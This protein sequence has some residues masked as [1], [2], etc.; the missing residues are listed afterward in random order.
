MG[1]VA[2]LLIQSLSGQSLTEALP[3]TVGVT[4]GRPGRYQL[5]Y[6]VPEQYWQA[7]SNKRISTGTTGEQ[8]EFRW[9]GCQSVVIGHHPMTGSYRYLPGQSFEECEIAEAPLWMVEQM[10]V[11]KPKASNEPPAPGKDDSTPCTLPIDVK[12]PLRACLGRKNRKLIDDGAPEGNR[13]NAGAA[14]ARDLIG[15]ANYLTSIGQAFD[16]NARELLE[17]FCSRCTPPLTGKECDRLWRSATKSNPTPCLSPDKIEAC[18]KAWHRKHQPGQPATQTGKPSQEIDVESEDTD[19]KAAQQCRQLQS[20]IGDYIRLNT[21][22]QEIELE[23]KPIQNLDLLYLQLACDY[24]IAISKE[25]CVDIVRKLA[26]H[27]PYSPVAEH[28]KKIAATVEPLPKEH[29]DRCAERYLGVTDDI[30]QLMLKRTLIAAVAR[31]LNPG[32]KV[33]T[34]LILHGP[35]GFYKSTFFRILG[36]SW[37]SDSL[38]DLRNIKDDLLVLHRYWI[39]EWGEIEKVTRKREADEIKSFI[40]KTEDDVR[41]PYGRAAQRLPRSCIL[42]GTTNR[43]EILR[44]PTGNRRF[45]IISIDRHIDIELVQAERDRLWAA[46]IAAYRAGETWHW[47]S[48]EVETVN[49]RASDYLQQDPLG[50]TDR[51]LSRPSQ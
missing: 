30:S 41:P 39:H 51:E 22:T 31:A 50:R 29:F 16:G 34:A 42:T 27:K 20:I 6:R 44:D 40:S 19:P 2:M 36:G 15:T 1:K 43:R 23:G 37:F 25:R 33:D 12:V 21:L 5:I 46:A 8:L 47:Q 9:N 13:D 26:F 24:R 10:L 18:I 14:L 35:Q 4:S 45:L 28:L 48:K 7:I 3:K 11:E 49:E 17:T 32:C 38:G